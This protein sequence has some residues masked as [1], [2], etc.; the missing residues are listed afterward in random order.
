MWW[1]E[2]ILIIDLMELNWILTWKNISSDFLNSY[3]YIYICVFSKPWTLFTLYHL[4]KNKPQKGQRQLVRKRL[5][6]NFVPMYLY[7]Q[8]SIHSRITE[9]QNTLLW[10]KRL[11]SNLMQSARECV[12][13]E[14]PWT[15]VVLV[16]QHKKWLSVKV[17]VAQLCPALCDPMDYTVQRILQARILEW[18]AIPFSRGSSQPRDWTQVSHTECLI[19]Y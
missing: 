7:F 9:I 12:S 14:V 16:G 10:V 3:I 1:I 6:R 4:E 13:V 15:W 2:I 11:S 17:K 19:S 5:R 18:I 8:C